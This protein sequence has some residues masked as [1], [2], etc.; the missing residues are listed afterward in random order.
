MKTVVCLVKG[1][2]CRID[3][4]ES[5]TVGFLMAK[6]KEQQPL[7]SFW[8][9]VYLMKRNGKWLKS[10]DPDAQEF[11]RRGQSNGIRAMMQKHGAMHASTE[12]SDPAIGFPDTEAIEDDDIHVFVHTQ[13]PDDHQL[14]LWAYGEPYHV[15]AWNWLRKRLKSKKAALAAK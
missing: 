14:D 1:K 10:G 11:M 8:M 5:L 6:V 4:N 3:L 13:S 12:I 9:D 7:Q 2:I 15:A